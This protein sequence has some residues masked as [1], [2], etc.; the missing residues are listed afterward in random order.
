MLPITPK[1]NGCGEARSEL[2][3][4]DTDI[5]SLCD[6]RQMEGAKNGIGVARYT[7]LGWGVSHHSVVVTTAERPGGAGPF[8]RERPT[9]SSSNRGDRRIRVPPTVTGR[10]ASRFIGEPVERTFHSPCPGALPDSSTSAVFRIRVH[11]LRAIR[12]APAKGVLR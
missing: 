12:V 1:G 5:P 3:R 10:T 4:H 11:Q 2:S 7:Y 8:G 9:D 6:R